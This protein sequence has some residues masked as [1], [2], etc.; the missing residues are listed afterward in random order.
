MR[1]VMNRF[2]LIC[3][4]SISFS[5]AMAGQ[6][7]SD[8][9]WA[10]LQKSAEAARMLSYR[11][12]VNCQS[13]IRVQSLQITH[14][15][16]AEGEFSRVVVLDGSPKEMLSKG[17]SV[18]I[19]N[20][21]NEKLVIEKRHGQ[22]LFPAL[23]PANMEVVKE[24]YQARVGNQEQV[25]GREVQVVFLNP[26]DRYRYGYK[27]WADREYGLLLKTMML[28]EK[29]E[30]IEQMAFSQLT[31]MNGGI[32]EW[33]SAKADSPRSFFA[34]Q[35][36]PVKPLNE[37]A[38]FWKIGQLPA[39]YRKIDQMKRQVPGKTMAVDHMIFSDGLATVSVFIEPI[40]K[41]VRPRAGFV[42]MGATGVFAN[43]AGNYQIVAVG[44]VPEA[45]VTQIAKA[46]SFQKQDHE[47]P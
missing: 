35:S 42:S 11:G 23:F 46:I 8:E 38:G 2:W 34:E 26:R 29:S 25:A 22:H 44:N 6:E 16:N 18:V 41:G 33:F 39:G 13:G 7:S 19:Y 28:N 30:A 36:A 10:I 3:L 17:G 15:N 31:L 37:A 20:P 21:I 24:G 40:I 43:I 4:C 1:D 47:K 14:I 27:L 5:Q 45:A 9:A 12:V 32:A